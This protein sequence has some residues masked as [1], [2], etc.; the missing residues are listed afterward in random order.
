MNTWALLRINRNI[1]EF[2]EHYASVSKRIW[3]WINRNIMEFKVVLTALIAAAFIRINRIILE[4]V[5]FEI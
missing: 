5:I 1:M 3:S 4:N 2:K